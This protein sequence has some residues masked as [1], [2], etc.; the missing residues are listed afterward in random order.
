MDAIV[1]STGG[2]DDTVLDHY[3]RA[4]VPNAV[5][6]RSPRRGDRSVQ[7]GWRGGEVVYAVVAR[8]S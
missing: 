7:H 8:S 6:V 1:G 5:I 4:V 3:R 2:A